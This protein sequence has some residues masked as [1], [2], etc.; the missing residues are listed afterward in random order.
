MPPTSKSI[1]KQC[2]EHLFTGQCSNIASCA[3]KKHSYLCRPCGSIIEIGSNPSFETHNMVA[4]HIKRIALNENYDTWFCPSCSDNIPL[5]EQHWRDHISKPAHPQVIPQVLIPHISE[6]VNYCFPCTRIIRDSSWKSHSSGQGHL[7]MQIVALYKTQYEQKLSLANVVEV[8]HQE[9]VNFGLIDTS[10]AHHGTQVLVK[11]TTLT[12]GLA[13]SSLRVTRGVGQQDSPHFHVPFIVSL[14][15]TLGINQSIEIPVTLKTSQRGKLIGV[16]V[17]VVKNT[18]NGSIVNVPARKL[19]AVVGS[20]ADHDLLKAS[21]TYV[22][23]KRARWRKELETLEGERPP[24]LDSAPWVRSL[25]QAPIPKELYD[26]FAKGATR[27]ALE[28]LRNEYFHGELSINS[29][30]I[31]FSRLLWAEEART[32]E[33]LRFYDMHAVTLEKEEEGRLYTLA[34][35]GL[36]EKRPSVVFGDTVLAQRNDRSNGRTYKGFVHGI[37]LDHIRVSFHSSFDDTARY[38]IRFEFNRITI[39]RQH[40]ALTAPS[41]SSERLLFPLLGDQGVPNTMTDEQLQS[42]I[43]TFNP[44]I[45]TNV[46]QLQAIKSIVRLKPGSAPFIIFGPPGT[47][48]TI[49][50]VE[51]IRQVLD[52]D[53]HAKVLACAPSNSAADLLAQ[54]LSIAFSPT[55][56]FRCNAISRMRVT[57]SA[58]LMQY[59]LFRGHRFAL[60][61]LEQLNSY[62]LII[63]TC[64]NASF[65]YNV[66]IDTGHFTHIFIDE[67]GQAS[68]PEVLQAIKAISGN[69]TQVVLSG[70]PKQLGPVVRSSIARHFGLGKSYLERLM[71]QP[72]YNSDTAPT[73]AF[74]KLVKNFRSH[75]AILHYPNQQFYEGDLE[76]CGDPAA[77]NAF[78]GSPQLVNPAFPVVFQH[79]P[80]ENQ[81]EDTSPS[82]FNILEATEVMERIKSLLA[83]AAHPVRPEDIAVITPYHAQGRKIRLLLKQSTIEGVTV[84]SVE[85]IQGQERPVIIVSTVRSSRDLLS[86]DAKF[87]LGFVA[88]PRRF[89][90]AVTRAKGLLIV[91]GDSNVLSIDPIWRGFLNYVHRRGGWSGDAPEWDTAAP[92]DM[93]A[94]YAAEMREAAAND[95]DALLARLEDGPDLEAEANVERPFEEED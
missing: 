22:K 83:D 7:K 18:S 53:P 72:V 4:N 6:R 94:D 10:V 64:G 39:C 36:S 48:K 43:A 28:Q 79:L 34:V 62:K 93:N 84:C 29:H 5:D 91:I 86:Y 32:I 82:Y 44:L 67:A 55:D 19:T 1:R 57:L 25:P 60:P 41:V 27:A 54:R 47:G 63:S 74:V 89:N 16:L 59:S 33:D 13:L 68:E 78:I 40:Q 52:R 3:Y 12:H 56:M 95:M 81:R 42:P 23:P 69:D 49:T 73:R 37:Q 58:E 17:L 14:G 30:S 71:E 15:S 90:V 9:G 87:T 70:D 51:A 92:V 2:P 61:S 45:S 35:P 26:I 50:M 80:G 21:T 88:N 46:A 65:P 24:A 76:V 85:Q 8:S 66:G 20:A 11:L 38:N 75:D 31:W 77:I